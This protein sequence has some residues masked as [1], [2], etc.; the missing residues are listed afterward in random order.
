[1]NHRPKN[2]SLI[3][4]YRQP[5][6]R[7]VEIVLLDGMECA[8][9]VFADFAAGLDADPRTLHPLRQLADV[10]FKQEVYAASRGIS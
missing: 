5:D 7:D 10:I 8:V 4:G 9:H 2:G 6:L 1:M 3:Q